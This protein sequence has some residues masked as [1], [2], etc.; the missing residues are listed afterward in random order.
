MALWLGTTNAV[1]AKL[2][3][4]PQRVRQLIKELGI[5]PQMVGKSM[6]L[7]TADIKRLEKRKTQRGPTKEKK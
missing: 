4:T 3:I 6:I 1:A 2:G 5:E 7:D